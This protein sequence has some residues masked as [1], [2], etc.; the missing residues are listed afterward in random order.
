MSAVNR[1][2]ISIIFNQFRLFGKVTNS[3]LATS[4]RFKS[5]KAAVL[6]EFKEN[7]DIKEI[8]LK[9][10]RKNE[11]RVKVS[12][13]SLNQSDLLMCKGEYD[14]TPK[15]PFVPGHEISG[16]IIEVGSEATKEGFTN[17]QKVVGLSKDDYGGL[18]QQIT[19]SA[20]DVWL[21]PQ[22]IKLRKGCVLA[23]A[24]ATA[25][26]GL[27]R[28]GRLK[29][30]QSV[31]VTAASGGLGLAAVDVA[32]NVYRAKVIAVCA[33][34]EQ[35]S[36]LRERGAWAA[37]TYDPKE[38]IKKVEEVT[39]GR[40]VDLVFDAVGGKVFEHVTKCVAH[41]GTV[42]LAGFA[43]RTV[44]QVATGI[45]LPCSMSLVGIS[46]GSYRKADLEIYRTTVQDAIDMCEQGLTAPAISKIFPLADV[47]SAFEYMEGH[48][49]TGKVVVQ[50]KD[51]D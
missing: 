15:L 4:A 43:S 10:L 29:E 36:L 11:V 7:L 46:L 24:Y 44:Q 51:E 37:L 20:T 25:L 39:D 1:K 19:L 2:G 49:T 35:A 45:L 3:D 38:V 28:R 32:A 9:K 23:D 34:E 26:L 40:G 47:N 6:R 42:I 48:E 18:A 5:V 21:L 30:K 22:S 31:L 13:C 16:E 8:P 33:S 41:E 50:L 17:G 14:F 12:Y 27:T